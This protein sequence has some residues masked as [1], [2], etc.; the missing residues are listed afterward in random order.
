MSLTRR[1]RRRLQRNRLLA[2]KPPKVHLEPLE[3]RILLSADLSYTMTGAV[4]DLTLT[5]DKVEGV[6]TLQLINNVDPDSATQVIA[7][8]ALA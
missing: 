5:L 2:R 6:D 8:L 1:I 7:S 3:P 4:K